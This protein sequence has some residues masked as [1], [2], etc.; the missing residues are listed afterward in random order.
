MY[1]KINS[2]SSL[3]KCRLGVSVGWQSLGRT[4]RLKDKTTG[5]DRDP[6]LTLCPL[7]EGE[8][9]LVRIHISV[10]AN[11]MAALKH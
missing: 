5:G 2:V 1:A 8:G 3:R 7:P 11:G 9:K 6:A 10:E 4:T